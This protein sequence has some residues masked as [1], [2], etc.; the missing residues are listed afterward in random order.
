MDEPYI[1]TSSYFT[2]SNKLNPGKSGN[3]YRTQEVEVF[4]IIIN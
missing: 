1:T 2:D 3:Y 4:K